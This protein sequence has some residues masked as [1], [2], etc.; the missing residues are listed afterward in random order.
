MSHTHEDAPVRRRSLRETLG[1]IVLG[2][3]I[4]IIFLGSLLLFGLGVANP[5]WALGGGATLIVLMIIAIASLRSPLGVA[6]GWLVQA[7]VVAA[8]FL[9]P[10]FFIVG[11]LF[12]ALWTYC[13][14]SASRLNRI[15][16]RTE[17][18]NS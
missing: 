6:L 10:S 1:A 16:N 14:I 4:I 3:E 11:A 13:M 18:E 7:A 15:P 8:G 12:T 2:F 9:T 5:A 17:Q